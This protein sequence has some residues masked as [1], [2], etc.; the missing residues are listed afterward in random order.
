MENSD[1]MERYFQYLFVER[2]VSL[3]TVENYKEDLSIFFRRFPNK[4]GTDDYLPSDPNDFVLLESGDGLSAA[5]IARRLSCLLGFY[6]FLA[7]E[8]IIADLPDKTDRPKLPKKLPTVLTGEEIE[9][10]LEAPNMN[11]D[12]GI[13]DRAMLETMYASGLRVSELCSLRLD[14]VNVK[15]GF[16]TIRHG[17]GNKQRSVPI[18]SFALEYLKMYLDGPR[19]R[20]KGHSS[21]FVFLNREGKPISRVYF[22]MQVKRYAEEVGLDVSISPH[23]L[24]HCFATHLLENGAELRAVQEMLGHAHLSTTQIYT[25]VSSRRILSAYDKFSSR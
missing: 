24:R 25:H 19:K 22:F 21:P 2:G 18:G 13:R 15:N 23:T 4:R 1:A 5:T 17:K 12:S 20:N 10:L 14:A 7:K 8:G 16:I 11:K 3:Q 9:S 6:S